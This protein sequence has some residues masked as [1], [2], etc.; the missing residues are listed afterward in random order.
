MLFNFY[1][2][3][4]EGLIFHKDNIEESTAYRDHQIF[5][6]IEFIFPKERMIRNDLHSKSAKK[7]KFLE[8]PPL[9]SILSC[10]I[11]HLLLIFNL[12]TLLKMPNIS[13]HKLRTVHIFTWTLSSTIPLAIQLSQ[14]LFSKN[15]NV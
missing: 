10:V 7:K 4:I 14:F 11:F 12:S 15:P 13:L 2:R 5:S 6:I 9:H 1:V 3:T 8:S